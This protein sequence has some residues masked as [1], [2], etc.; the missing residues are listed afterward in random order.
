MIKELQRSN[1][2]LTEMLTLLRSGRLKVQAAAAGG[3]APGGDDVPTRKP[4]LKS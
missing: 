2:T 4:K 3:K 1:Q